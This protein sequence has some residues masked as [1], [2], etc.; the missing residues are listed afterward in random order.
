MIEP[1]QILV[2]HLHL[3][4][5]GKVLDVAMGMGR[6]S[7]YLA[8]HGF[9]VVGLER[10]PAAIDT[11]LTEAKRRGIH[12]DARRTDLE[13]SDSCQMERNTYD[14]IICFYYLQRN[15]IPSLK[16]ALKPG[17]YIIYETFLI[18]QHIKTGHPEHRDY[19]L[20]HNELLRLFQDFRVISYCEGQDPKG[21][22][23]ASLVA[24]KSI[25]PL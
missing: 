10:D 12:V 17:G 25:P 18:D 3:L 1:A 19:C 16:D 6:H 2:E 8:A 5:K 4:P 9:D 20:A 7:L 15:L 22:Y 21:T 13:D 23:K 11:C 24:R 14:V